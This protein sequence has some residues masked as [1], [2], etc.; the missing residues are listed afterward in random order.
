MRMR[1]GGRPRVERLRA[2][3]VQPRDVCEGRA[4]RPRVPESLLCKQMAAADDDVA[5]ASFEAATFGKAASTLQKRATSMLLYV[6][7]A[8]SC[9]RLRLQGNSC[10]VRRAFSAMLP[11]SLREPEPRGAVSEPE[12]RKE[13]PRT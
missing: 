13:V 4:V 7:W 5:E 8:A 9:A 2:R 3:Q 1:G 6:R 11:E 10:Y 12:L